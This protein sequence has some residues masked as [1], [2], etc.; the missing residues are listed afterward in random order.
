MTSREKTILA[1][2][3][4]LSMAMPVAFAAP[5]CDAESFRNAS[6]SLK[7]Y[8]GVEPNLAGQ[9]RRDSPAFRADPNFLRFV[10]ADLNSI[11]N[12][13]V[14][15]T[16]QFVPPCLEKSRKALLE[17][18]AAHKQALMAY[19]QGAML[20]DAA[21]R[22]PRDAAMKDYQRYHDESAA[23]AKQVTPK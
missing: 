8:A 19:R 2:F 11:K 5:Y 17:A 21:F 1:A 10:D 7:I 13:E 9:E 12:A 14:L 22:V 3:A 18:L 20:T 4:C 6:S 23:A 16:A 15:A